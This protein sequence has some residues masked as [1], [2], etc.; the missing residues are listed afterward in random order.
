MFD[1]PHVLAAVL[2]LDRG[3]GA[4]LGRGHAER[5]SEIIAEQWTV[6]AQEKDKASTPPFCPG[7]PPATALV[8]QIH[9][10]NAMPSLDCQ[11][12]LDVQFCENS[13]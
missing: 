3:L 10:E 4:H 13:V 1:L 8:L 5:V 9:P 7:Q 2:L 6:G 11:P 12:H